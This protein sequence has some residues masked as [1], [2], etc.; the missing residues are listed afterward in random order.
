MGGR[1]CPPGQSCRCRSDCIGNWGPGDRTP[2]D[3][4]CSGGGPRLNTMA[5]TTFA[6][7]L[8][9]TAAPTTQPTTRQPTSQPS[10]SP[11]LY[12]TFAP[13]DGPTLHPCSGGNHGCDS[14]STYVRGSDPASHKQRRVREL[15]KKHSVQEKFIALHQH[16]TRVKFN[17]LRGG[18]TR[19]RTALSPDACATHARGCAGFRENSRRAVGALS[20]QHVA[21]GVATEPYDWIA[22]PS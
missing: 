12:P 3:A 14:V 5:P 19:S 16:K 15:R 11:T 1:W 8:A 7:T 2:N 18:R 4:Y 20:Q 10:A 9:P 22:H 21:H 6:P 17:M 13:T